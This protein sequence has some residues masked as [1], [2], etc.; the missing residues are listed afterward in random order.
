MAQ[1]Y[2]VGAAALRGGF[3][4]AS[5][6]IRIEG[7]AGVLNVKSSNPGIVRQEFDYPPPLA[8]AEQML[9]TLCDGVVKKTRHDVLVD[10]ATFEIDEFLGNNAG[11]VVAEIELDDPGQKFPVPPWLGREV[12]DLARYYNVKLID[13]PYTRWSEAEK[14]PC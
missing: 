10:G 1:G 4:R 5:V 12:S 9:A 2:L 11:L 14:N 8:D 3:A 7:A 6:R 13:H